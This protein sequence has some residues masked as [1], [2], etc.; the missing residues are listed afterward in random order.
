MI[1]LLILI[2]CF[3]VFLYNLYYVS[4]EDFLIV[5]KDIT[6]D[7]IFNLAFVAGFVALLFARIFFVIFNPAQQFLNIIGFMAFPYFPGL[8]LIGG[9]TGGLVCTAFYSKAKKLPIGKIIDL[10]TISL[11]GV[12]PIGFLLFFIG[13]WGKVSLDF[14]ALFI[15]AF[16][17]SLILIKVIYKFSTRGEIKDGSFSLIFLSSFS[18]IYFLINLFTNLK[19]FSFFELENIF[20][21][22]VIFSSL[23]LLVNHEIMEKILEKK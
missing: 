17:I 21:F 19:N 14:N 15:A 11:V 3:V 5:R 2:I 22:V 9:I 12:L 10:F 6:T 23:I 13:F 7:K 18:L 8:S 16:I 4:H 1:F 20:L